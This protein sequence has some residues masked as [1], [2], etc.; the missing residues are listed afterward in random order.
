[1]LDFLWPELITILTSV[2]EETSMLWTKMTIFPIGANQLK[3]ELYRVD[4]RK[5]FEY[6]FQ[7]FIIQ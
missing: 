6:F 1:M 3:K 7:S 2:S 5:K 4:I